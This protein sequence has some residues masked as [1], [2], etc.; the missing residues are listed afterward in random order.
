MPSNVVRLAIGI[1]SCIG[2]LTLFLFQHIDWASSILYF[3]ESIYRFIWNRTLRFILNDFFAILL[4][5]ALFP[6]RKYVVFAIWVQIAG[7]IFLLIPYFLLKLSYPKYNGPLIN[8]LHRIILNP[9]L[10]L[11]LIPALYWQRKNLNSN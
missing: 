3:D 11:L 9:T 10:I 6:Q 1:F 4:V 7:F 8:F 5:Y 2:L